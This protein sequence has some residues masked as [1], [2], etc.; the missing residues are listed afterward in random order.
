MSHWT[1]R[2]LALLMLAYP[3]FANEAEAGLAGQAASALASFGRSSPVQS[4][5]LGGDCWYHDG[6]NGP[7][8]YR[9]GN[10]WNSGLGWIGPIAPF[11]APAIR[12]HHHH[13][14]GA[15]NAN[16]W[17][18][19]NPHQGV[20]PFERPAVRAPHPP[21][22]PHASAPSFGAGSGLRRFGHGGF[23]VSPR[24]HGGAPTAPQGAG[25]RFHGFAGG[26]HFHGGAG[27]PRMRAPASPG[28][29]GG[30]VRLPHIGAPATPG[31]GG[32]FHGSGPRIGVPRIGA[33]ASP[34]LAGSGG[35]RGFGG[36]IGAP[37]A[38][39]P[40]SPGVGGPRGAGGGIGGFRGGGAFSPGGQAGGHR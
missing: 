16:H 24:L 3:P 31:F 25:G 21:A 19:H 26:G 28:I 34:G 18:P 4:I 20:R 38:G 33:P 2:V 36:G 11:F 37:R 39:A 6:W 17:G 10:E 15:A 22:G 30:A 14:Y 12:R 1:L 7:G 32:G 8:W 35:F 29:A 9:C 27:G 5:Q 40:A 13:R 23:Q